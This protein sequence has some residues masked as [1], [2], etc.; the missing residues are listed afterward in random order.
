MRWLSGQLAA[1]GFAQIKPWVFSG[2]LLLLGSITSLW[3]QAI[4]R[5]WPLA[6]CAGLATIGFCLEALSTRARIRSGVVAKFWPEVVDVISSGLQ[7]SARFEV[8]LSELAER[9]P[10]ALRPM[11]RQSI[12]NLDAGST[13]DFELERL[14]S[15]AAERHADA[16]LELIRLGIE[17]GGSELIQSLKDQSLQTRRDLALTAEIASKQGWVVA[18][19]KLALISPWVI[20]AMLALRPENAAVYNSNAG[21]AILATGLL[22]SVFAYR[23]IHYLAALPTQP[24]VLS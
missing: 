17:S 21:A 4:F 18:T 20:V 7:S 5:V 3:A 6:I 11:F 1:A 24:R 15:V 8:S 2:L 12:E 19:A 10:L 13:L 9:G 16:T 23:L 22:V 14:K